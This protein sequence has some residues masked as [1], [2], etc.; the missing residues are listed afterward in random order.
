MVLGVQVNGPIM[1]DVGIQCNILTVP[2][3]IP[4]PIP[5][6]DAIEEYMD[7]DVDNSASTS[8]GDAELNSS[9]YSPSDS[10]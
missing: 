5:A 6:D 3:T 7:I 9:M 4:M 8:T 1:H 2:E 10:G